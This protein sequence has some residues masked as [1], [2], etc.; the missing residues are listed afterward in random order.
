[1]IDLVPVLGMLA[2]VVGVADTV[3]YVRDILRGRPG[4]IAARG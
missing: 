4:L 1:M 2:V 3:P